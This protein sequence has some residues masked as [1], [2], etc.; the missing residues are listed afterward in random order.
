MDKMERNGRNKTLYR[1][2]FNYV[3]PKLIVD[4]GL[5]DLWRRKNPDSSEF[6][7]Y[8]GSSEWRS[9][10]DKTYT[11]IKTANNTKINNIM[12]FFTDHYNLFLLTGSPQRLKLEKILHTLIILF[13]VSLSPPWL[14]R[15]FFFYLKHKT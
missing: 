3:L 4:N 11:D 1:C 12:V 2:C 6:T 9:R 13:Y 7:H 5:E 8:C 14:Q 10:I 15:L